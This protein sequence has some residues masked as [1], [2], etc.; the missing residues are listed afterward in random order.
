MTY[1]TITDAEIRFVDNLTQ[2]NWMRQLVRKM[3]EPSF[4]KCFNP[5]PSVLYIGPRNITFLSSEDLDM[6]RVA[7]EII[8]KTYLETIQRAFELP[9]FN[10]IHINE[11]L[12]RPISNELKKEIEDLFNIANRELFQRT[13][14][15][16]LM[17]WMR[18]VFNWAPTLE[19]HGIEFVDW[20]Q[21]NVE[22]DR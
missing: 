2:K 13:A 17:M 11:Y 1:D 16:I 4:F 7:I 18:S 21:I 3:A 9:T 14:D 15:T 5:E 8:E 10:K 6:D 20:D 19:Q 22:Q 12:N